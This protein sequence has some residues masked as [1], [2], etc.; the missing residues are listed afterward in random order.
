MTPVNSTGYPTESSAAPLSYTGAVSPRSISTTSTAFNPNS[1]IHARLSP[2]NQ[3]S[4]TLQTG[5]SDVRVAMPHPH[6]SSSWQ[7]GQHPMQGSQ[8]Q[9][10]HP[11]SQLGPSARGWDI[12]ANYIESPATAGIPP[13]QAQ[14]LNFQ[15]PRNADTSDPQGENAPPRLSSS[16][17]QSQQ[18]RRS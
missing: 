14:N 11:Q 3:K 1:H 9:H 13:P 5:T 10:Q 6:E 16:R 2:H 7:S 18:V 17:Q 15:T 12:S 8:Y 4:M